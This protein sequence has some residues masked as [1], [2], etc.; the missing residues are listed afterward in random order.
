MYLCSWNVRGLG[1][2]DKCN[3]VLSELLSIKSNLLLLQETKLATP[4]VPKVRS[5]LPIFLDFYATSPATGTAGCLL[6][7]ANTSSL[8][9]TNHSNHGF[10]STLTFTS[11][12]LPSPFCV[13]N[14]YGPTNRSEKPIFLAEL[15]AIAPPENTPWLVVGDFNL[16]RFPHEKNNDNFH[17]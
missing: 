7:A 1:D 8:H 12:T 3:D 5:F 11:L 4:S 9:I 13:T 2:A 17:Q 6:S 14:V 10:C 15:K 16:I